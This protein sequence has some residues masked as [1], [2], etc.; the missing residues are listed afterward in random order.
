MVIKRGA[1]GEGGQMDEGSQKFQTSSY[2]IESWGCNVH[3]DYS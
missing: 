1:L 3:E 2:K